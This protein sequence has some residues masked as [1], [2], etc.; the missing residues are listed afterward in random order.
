MM[1]T[2]TIRVVLVDDQESFRSATRLLIG[3]TEGFELV[4]EAG[5][6]EEG[7][8]LA[9]KSSADLVLMDIG[10]P[11]IDGL[12]AARRIVER[13]PRCKVVVLSTYQGPEYRSRAL[14]AGAVAF[15]SKSKFD[16]DVL[17]EVWD[18]ASL[19]DGDA[20]GDQGAGSGG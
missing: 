4:S 10:L 13:D 19:Q 14:A 6:G 11:G 12:E 3:M 16:P 9:E 18:A 2:R 8:E 15:V 20:G 5:S 17:R 7:M 1:T